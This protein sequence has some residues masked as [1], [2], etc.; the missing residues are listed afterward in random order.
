MSDI[1][2]LALYCAML[3]LERATHQL[4]DASDCASPTAETVAYWDRKCVQIYG[5]AKAKEMGCR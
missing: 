5:E 4:V 3:E 1:A 2:R